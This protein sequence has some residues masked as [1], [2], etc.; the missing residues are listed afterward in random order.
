VLWHAPE[1]AR[2][3]HFPEGCIMITSSQ[4][5]GIRP[6]PFS[7][8]GRCFD[9]GRTR[10]KKYVICRM[11]DAALNSKADGPRPCGNSASQPAACNYCLRLHSST[12]RAARRKTP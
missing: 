6:N 7:S 11:A 3:R 12:P 1:I 10:S 2:E 9:G 4:S 5:E 8:A